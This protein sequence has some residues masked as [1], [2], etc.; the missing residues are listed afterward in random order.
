[1]SIQIS[2]DMYLRL[3][4]H[5]QAILCI[6]IL[7]E[8]FGPARDRFYIGSMYC[9][10]K[11]NHAKFT[12]ETSVYFRNIQLYKVHTFFGTEYISYYG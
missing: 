3:G 7:S 8:N 1:M 9:V 12:K 10:L 4:L 5:V 2:C 11:T 6:A